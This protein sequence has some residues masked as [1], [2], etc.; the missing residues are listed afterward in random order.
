[1]LDVPG[2]HQT[3]EAPEKGIGYPDGPVPGFSLCLVDYHILPL[4][5]EL[6]SLARRKT[7]KYQML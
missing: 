3:S 6:I 2:E 1:M 5:L 7:F 4:T